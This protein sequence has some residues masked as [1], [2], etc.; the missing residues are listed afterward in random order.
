MHTILFWFRN[1]LRMQDH[2]PMLQAAAHATQHGQRLLL[3]YVH[4]P[5]QDEAT[6]WG[7]LRMGVHRRRFVADSLQDLIASL[8]T[9][10]Q[11]LVLLHGPAHEAL[12][13]CARRAQAQAIFCEYIAAPEEQAQVQ[14]LRTAGFTVN[15]VWQSSL[16]EPEK[17]PFEVV[18]MPQVFTAFR[19]R[20]E[21]AGVQPLPP[22]AAPAV[23]P[24]PPD[25]A[26][27]HTLPGWTDNPWTLLQVQQ[28]SDSDDRS[29]FPDHLPRCQG[30]E[31]SA[32]AHLQSYLTPPWP[33]RYK[34]TRNALQGQHTSSHW[35][36]WLATGALSVRTIWTALQTYEQQHG[37]NDGTYWLWFELLWRDNFRFLHLQHGRQL[38]AARG[39][40]QL[41]RPSHFPKDFQRWCNGDTGEP[42]VDAGMREL[43]CT[44]YT[45]NRMRQIVASYLVHDLACDWRSGAAWFE[46]QLV[47]FD[48]YSNQGNWLYVSGR[49]TDPRQG[50]RFNPVKQTQDH[51]P[52][53]RYRKQWLSR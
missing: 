10:G 24:P 11:Q 45:S 41:P 48:V 53:G 43:A 5:A 46:S 51:D 16:L 20:I 31:T 26:P 21:A 13:E 27:L 35:S 8:Q 52:Q 17:L 33:D 49:G 42:I 14:A 28:T 15:T 30:G 6:A 22:L 36:P 12:A 44:G 18:D 3:V 34:Q 4:D 40:S 2:R 32:R 29:N 50:R 23:L 9:L 38:Y 37:A 47:D 1:D 39:L 7:F 19:Q 25:L